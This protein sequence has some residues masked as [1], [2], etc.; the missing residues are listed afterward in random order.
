MT[1]E[2]VVGGMKVMDAMNGTTVRGGSGAQGRDNGTVWT[3]GGVRVMDGI[4]VCNDEDDKE[5]GQC[6][7]SVGLRSSN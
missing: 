3:R 7:A 6:V 4:A 2:C 5:T 1:R